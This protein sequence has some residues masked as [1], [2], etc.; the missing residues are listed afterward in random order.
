M[1]LP[2]IYELN[3]EV[4]LDGYEWTADRLYD[5]VLDALE[6]TTATELGLI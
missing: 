5:S 2:Y 6:T 1:L 4:I 3:T